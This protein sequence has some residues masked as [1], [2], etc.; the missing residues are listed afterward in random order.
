[1]SAAFPGLGHILLS[2]HLKD[3][4]FFIWE[5]FINYEANI[6]LAILYSI[7]AVEAQKKPLTSNGCLY[8][9]RHTYSHMGQLQTAVDLNGYYMLAAREDPDI[10][11]QKMCSVENQLSR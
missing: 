10:E 3:F 11:V 7:T 8:I 1:V 5:V 4:S 6:N 2:K 9:C